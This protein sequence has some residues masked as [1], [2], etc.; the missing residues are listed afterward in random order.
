MKSGAGMPYKFSRCICLQTPDYEKAIEFYHKTMGLD[1]TG[2]IEQSAEL[3]AE[4]NRLFI[5]SAKLPL[6]PILEFLVPDV[7]AARDELLGAGC[8]VVS[9]EGKGGCCYMRDPFGFIFNLYQ[10]PEAFE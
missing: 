9:W 4:Q 3:K 7:E 10:E 8:E 6:G 5:D 1:L 2:E